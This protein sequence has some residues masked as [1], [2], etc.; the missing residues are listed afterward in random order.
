MH[1][2]FNYKKRFITL[3]LVTCLCAA[4]CGNTDNAPAVE[5]TTETSIDSTE[6]SAT[7]ETNMENDTSFAG[8]TT[9]TTEDSSIEENTVEETVAD[10][11]TPATIIA[12]A[13]DIEETVWYEGDLDIRFPEAATTDMTWDKMLPIILWGETDFI[14]SIQAP[15]TLESIQAA[16]YQLITEAGSNAAFLS[17]GN[18][19]SYIVG[20]LNKASSHP[21]Y[22]VADL[23][24]ATLLSCDTPTLQHVLT[25]FG[26]P[27]FGFAYETLEARYYY[28]FD[29]YYLE[30]SMSKENA[31]DAAWNV[32]EIL[33]IDATAYLN[34]D[35][36]QELNS[37]KESGLNGFVS[38][39]LAPEGF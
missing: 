5:S 6:A 23:D 25:T 1:T 2:I 39:Y 15:L 31:S 38:D 17:D 14:A 24:T 33:Y 37:I 36:E 11:H 9:A 22:I 8:E 29:S 26:T 27:D 32:S 16:G 30:I 19:Q 34:Q 13:T 7:T 18:A 35:F 4:G 3:S 21:E 20:Y 28:L 10:L 12:Y